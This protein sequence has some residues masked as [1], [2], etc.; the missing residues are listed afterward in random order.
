MDLA[1]LADV[2]VCA[3]VL[4]HAI[5]VGILVTVEV[6]VLARWTI[7]EG[8]LPMR[9]RWNKMLSEQNPLRDRFRGMGWIG[10]RNCGSQR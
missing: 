6:F 8:G 5:V 9:L 10:A 2:I 7:A 3:R 4:A 1:G